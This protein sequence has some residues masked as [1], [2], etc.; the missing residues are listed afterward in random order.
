MD[1]F[2]FAIHELPF[3]LLDSDE[4]FLEFIS[5]KN[6]SK[7]NFVSF[8]GTELSREFGFVLEKVVA[9]E[10]KSSE[11][12]RENEILNRYHLNAIVTQLLDELDTL[13]DQSVTSSHNISHRLLTPHPPFLPPLPHQRK[14]PVESNTNSDTRY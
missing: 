14:Y 2:L 1:L 9:L 7:W 6:D 13:R 11:F 12:V 8:A 4:T 10:I 5:T 3:L